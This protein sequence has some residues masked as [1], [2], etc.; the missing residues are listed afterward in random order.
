MIIKMPPLSNKRMKKNQVILSYKSYCTSFIVFKLPGNGYT[1]MDVLLTPTQLSTM[2]R[3][4][5]GDK[6]PDL[7]Q[8]SLFTIIL[9]LL[10]AKST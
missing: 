5:L 10:K 7:K 3:C 6:S 2:G 8:Y 4:C 1:Y 9:P